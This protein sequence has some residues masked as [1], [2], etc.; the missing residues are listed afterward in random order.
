MSCSWDVKCLS[1]IVK[2]GM[3]ANHAVEFMRL[4]IV[5]AKVLAKLDE[6]ERIENSL[7][8]DS[9]YGSVN[10]RFFAAHH[11]HRL[12]PVNEY[13]VVDNECGAPVQCDACGS[14]TKCVLPADHDVSTLHSFKKAP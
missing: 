11:T 3:D 14:W 2:M 8:L 12:A 13:G 7:V 5:N 6:L 1:C 4:L 9:S 10:T